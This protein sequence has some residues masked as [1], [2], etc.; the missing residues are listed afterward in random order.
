MGED[1]TTGQGLFARDNHEWQGKDHGDLLSVIKEV[2]PHVL[3]GI[4][5]ESKA[6][7]EEV[8]K[9]MSKYVSRPIILPLSNPTRPHE[10]DPKD[11]NEWPKSKVVIAT[12]SPF[13]PVEYNEKEYKVGESPRRTPHSEYESQAHLTAECNNSMAFPS[14]G[15]GAVLTRSKLL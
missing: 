6:F 1:L 11:V 7:T 12:G 10:A 14:I 4:S 5:P 3:I 2:K 13:P 15:L 9:E 8:V